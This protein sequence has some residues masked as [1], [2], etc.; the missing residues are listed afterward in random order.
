MR[1]GY[2]AQVVQVGRRGVLSGLVGGAFELGVLVLKWTVIAAIVAMGLMV[3]GLIKFAGWVT[4][5]A[6]GRPAVQWYRDARG[7]WRPYV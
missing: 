6:R 4:G 7:D 3:V 5:E 1:R 2:A